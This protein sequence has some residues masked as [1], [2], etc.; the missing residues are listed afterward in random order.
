MSSENGENGENGETHTFRVGQTVF[1]VNQRYTPKS[2]LGKGSYGVVVSAFDSVAQKIVALKKIPNV[3]S[4]VTFA[5]RSLREIRFLHHARNHHHIISLLDIFEPTE[6]DFNDLYIVLEYMQTD[7]HKTIYSKTVIEADHRQYFLYQLVSALKY[8]HSAG[9]VHRDVKPSNILLNEDCLL[10]L[11][12]F[13]LARNIT[14]DSKD[15]E[16]ASLTEY[17]VSRWY[18]APE[19][20]LC[21][22][23]YNTKIDMW[24]VGCILAELNSR[25]PFFAGDDCLGQLRA[26][27]DIRGTPIFEDLEAC[28]V[29]NADALKILQSLPTCKQVELNT[30]F[31]KCSADEIDFMDKLLQ[32]NPQK[33]ISAADA[34]KHPFLARFSSEVAIDCPS[35]FVFD[36]Q[37][38]A[39]LSKKDLQR[40]FMEDIKLVHESKYTA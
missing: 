22:S 6:E 13:N 20:V 30:L 29:G 33:R 32:F 37:N 12:D 17:V 1:T 5:K 39:K 19:V 21:S 14:E 3:F 2:C 24:S 27:L 15:D 25:R 11:C 40:I 8:V 34:L 38:E 18:R 35:K 36:F 28:C 9:V 10:K 7:L 31:P 16:S 26:I 4:D 23:E